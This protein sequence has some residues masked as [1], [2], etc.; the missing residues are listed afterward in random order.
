MLA[1]VSRRKAPL[2][3][4]PQ[5][6]IELEAPS[7]R[8]I[9]QNRVLI[10]KRADF[11]KKMEARALTFSPAYGI[12]S[13]IDKSNGG[14]RSWDFL[15][16]K[17]REEKLMNEKTSRAIAIAVSYTAPEEIGE[18]VGANFGKAV[19]KL[20]KDS[21]WV[22]LEVIL[23]ENVGAIVAG[24]QWIVKLDEDF[25]RIVTPQLKLSR[26]SQYRIADEK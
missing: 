14:F 20:N 13:R 4:I 5:A 6:L 19:F 9:L 23:R 1:T 12:T 25:T 18:D 2:C 7:L 10:A 8:G 3:R 17:K 21:T 16:A 26:N 24:D 15:T 11:F 22:E